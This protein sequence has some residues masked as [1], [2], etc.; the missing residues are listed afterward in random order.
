[1]EKKVLVPTLV[2]QVPAGNFSWVDQRL[3]RDGHLSKMTIDAVALYFFL[4]IVAD[5]N[6]LSYYSDEGVL[7]HLRLTPEALDKA[8]RD[9]VVLKLVAYRCPLYQVLSLQPSLSPCVV[10][11]KQDRGA[12]EPV[13]VGNLLRTLMERKSS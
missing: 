11:P 12:L 3:V 6:G 1:M 10:T 5:R 4:V 9:L 2:R 8:R 7:K 13:L